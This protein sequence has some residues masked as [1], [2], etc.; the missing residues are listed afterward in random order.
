MAFGKA[1]VFEELPSTCRS[2]LAG[3]S[4]SRRAGGGGGGGKPCAADG[5]ERGDFWARSH[6]HAGA[7]RSHKLLCG[8]A[9]ADAQLWGSWQLLA[10]VLGTW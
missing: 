10:L 7:E 2:A 5:P 4:R 1:G 3:G 9:S 8:K 6:L